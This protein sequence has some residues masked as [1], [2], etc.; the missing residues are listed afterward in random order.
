MVCGGIHESAHVYGIIHTW[1]ARPCHHHTHHMIPQQY[2]MIKTTLKPLPSHYHTTPTTG[3]HHTHHRI[4]PHPPTWGMAQKLNTLWLRIRERYS[5][6]SGMCWRAL[7]MRWLRHCT[8]LSLFS[9][10]WKSVSFSPNLL[11][12]WC[13][14]WC[15]V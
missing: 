10:C 5:R 7:V 13:S 1:Q 4:K 9:G 15:V 3:S 2:H 12:P 14:V 11:H 6:T 8:A